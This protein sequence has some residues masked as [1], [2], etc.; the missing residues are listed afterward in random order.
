[1]INNEK[2]KLNYTDEVEWFVNAAK[3][4]QLTEKRSLALSSIK[5]ASDPLSFIVSPEELN[6][7]AQQIKESPDIL[8]AS[9]MFV[10]GLS[11]LLEP[12]KDFALL[13][14]GGLK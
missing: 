11:K 7:L 3:R 6:S 1:M 14:P 4:C 12:Y 10:L 2:S 5:F 9:R 8:R 13:S